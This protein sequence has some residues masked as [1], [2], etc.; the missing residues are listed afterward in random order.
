MTK[1]TL[2]VALALAL[3]VSMWRGVD[4]SIE[5]NASKRTIKDLTKELEAS[6]ETIVDLTSALDFADAE[7]ASL[8]LD[9]D[10]ANAEL[11]NTPQIV[12]EIPRHYDIALP[13]ELQTFTYTTCVEHDIPEYYELVLALMQHESQFVDYVVSSTDDYGLMQI[14]KINHKWLAED[15]GLYNM[16]DPYENIQAGTHILSTYLHKYSDIAAALM[17][18]NMGEATAEYYWEQGIRSTTYSDSILAIYRE[19]IDIKINN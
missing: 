5:H 3:L 13:A 19:Y 16:L 14:N 6:Q 4:E 7:A 12:V 2:T 10:K 9:L 8:R 17:C 1:N 18:Y 15:L 11:Q